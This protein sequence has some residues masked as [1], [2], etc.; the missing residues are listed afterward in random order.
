[1][2]TS[3]TCEAPV[4]MPRLYYHGLGAF[5]GQT[6]GGRYR[7]KGGHWAGKPRRSSG[8]L[9]AREGFEPSHDGFADHSLRPLGYRASAKEGLK[10]PRK[11]L[12]IMPEIYAQS[13]AQRTLFLPIV[14]SF[15][16]CNPLIPHDTARK[17]GTCRPLPW[18]TWVPRGISKYSKSD[19]PLRT[20]PNNAAFNSAY[21]FSATTGIFASRK[22][23]ADSSGGVGL[24]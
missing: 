16:F 17:E 15:S 14:P 22:N 21:F 23:R 5:T 2:P 19:R 12:S 10:N 8:I 11:P 1:M 20:S 13:Y 24:M 7:H 3:T 6:D 18:A 4:P 9:E